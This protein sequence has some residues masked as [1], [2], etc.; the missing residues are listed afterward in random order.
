MNK[1]I[2]EAPQ[3]SHFENLVDGIKDPATYDKELARLMECEARQL[4]E[5]I[6]KNGEI[7]LI[8][9]PA[10]MAYQAKLGGIR[11]IVTRN[12]PIYGGKI[13]QERQ[14]NVRQFTTF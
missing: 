4:Y 1:K 13:S 9:N 14:T 12:K 7:S 5:S 8:Q 2:S 10:I 11:A 6:N 3:L